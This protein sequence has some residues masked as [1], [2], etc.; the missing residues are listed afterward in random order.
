MTNLFE[1]VRHLLIVNEKNS[2]AFLFVN[3]QFAA[4]EIVVAVQIS[5]K[6]HPTK[7]SIEDFIRKIIFHSGHRR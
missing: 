7:F 2:R 4:I 6:Y 3:F 1:Y 5:L